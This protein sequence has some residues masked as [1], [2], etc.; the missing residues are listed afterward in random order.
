LLGIFTSFLGPLIIYLVKKD[1]EFVSDQAREALNFQ[2]TLLI[3]HVIGVVTTCVV[4][5][6]FIVTAVWLVSIIFG[7]MGT[8]AANSGQR[9]RYP[10]SIRMIK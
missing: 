7:I 1:D 8:L 4:I 3:G 9:Y 6:W 10:V 5:G 2:L